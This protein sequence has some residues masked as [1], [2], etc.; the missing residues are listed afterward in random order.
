M[1]KERPAG[2]G[3][4]A[5]IAAAQPAGQPAGED[6]SRVNCGFSVFYHEILCNLRT[7]PIVVLSPN[8][9]PLVR[10]GI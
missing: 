9:R 4:Q 3:Q 8:R 10:R 2:Q 6:D 7:C 1:R 5:F